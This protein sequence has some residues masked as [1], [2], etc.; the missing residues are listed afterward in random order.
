MYGKGNGLDITS[1]GSVCTVLEQGLDD[2]VSWLCRYVLG[3]GL[4]D[5]ISW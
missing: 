5:Q 1:L 2:H 3:Y 4:D